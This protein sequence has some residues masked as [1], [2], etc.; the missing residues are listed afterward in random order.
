MTETATS[1]WTCRREDAATTHWPS[2]GLSHNIPKMKA[3]LERYGIHYDE[4]FF[5]STLH[6]SGYVADTVDGC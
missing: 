1:I 6:E 3:D 4:W 5:E 2:F